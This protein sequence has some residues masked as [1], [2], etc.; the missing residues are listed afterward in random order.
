VT[1]WKWSRNYSW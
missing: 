1:C